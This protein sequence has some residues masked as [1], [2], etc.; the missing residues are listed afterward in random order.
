METTAAKSYRA[1]Y[2]SLTETE[3][4]IQAMLVSGRTAQQIADLWGCTLGNIQNHK[5]RIGKKLLAPRRVRHG[6]PG[7][8]APSHPGAKTGAARL[9][10]RHP[11][12]TVRWLMPGLWVIA[13]SDEKLHV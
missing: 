5:S 11:G 6:I 8:Y 4:I 7:V 2:P 10:A 1:T 12:A 3:L 13:Q 9:A